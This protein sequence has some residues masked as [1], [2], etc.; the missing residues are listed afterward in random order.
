MSFG[1]GSP[2]CFERMCA[3]LGVVAFWRLHVDH[4]ANFGNDHE[5][6]VRNTVVNRLPHL[7]RRPHIQLATQQKSRHIDHC[8]C[9]TQ[10]SVGKRLQGCSGRSGVEVG[11]HHREL[12]DQFRL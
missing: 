7:T 2:R 6:G 8:E 4:V 10:V 5:S 3:N 11:E 1:S 9:V 12:I